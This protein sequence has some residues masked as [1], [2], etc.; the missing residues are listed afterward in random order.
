[1]SFDVITDY[2]EHL[3]ELG[4]PACDLSIWKDHK[5]IYRHMSGFRDGKEKDVTAKDIYWQFSTTKVVCCVAALHAMEH[6]LFSLDD[7]IEKYLPEFSNTYILQNKCK[8]PTKNKIK[9]WNLFTMTAGLSY[10]LNTPAIVQLAN[11]THAGIR[12]ISSAIVAEP[13][14]FEPGTDFQYSLCHDVL[15]MVIASASGKSLGE[16]L[17]ENI[18]R[19]IGM[20]NTGFFPSDAQKDNFTTHFLF[21]STTH[22]PQSTVEPRPFAI[23]PQ[24][25]SGGGGLFGTV[26]D[27]IRFADALSCCGKAWN[28]YQL[29]S[30]DSLN[31]LRKNQ[32][33]EQLLTSFQRKTGHA[34]NGY[35]LGVM[36]LLDQAPRHYCCPPGTFGWGGLAGTKLYSNCENH[37]SVFFA[38][39]V[40]DWCNYDQYEDHPHNKIINLLY[41]KCL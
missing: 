31:I 40:E 12:E 4:I 8:T 3:A 20:H 23:T 9:I 37:I 7:P 14:S 25:E 33:S 35:G 2:L 11:D 34:G 15:G 26:D 6:G 29:L 24:Y 5:E 36:V 17:D 1:M 32:L 16:Y 10:N 38:M 19:P 21:D 30:P 22:K 28:G 41:S 39:E 27:F 13:L 18:F